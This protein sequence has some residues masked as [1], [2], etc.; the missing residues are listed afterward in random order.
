MYIKHGKRADEVSSRGTAT[1]SQSEPTQLNFECSDGSAARSRPLRVVGICIITVMAAE[2][3]RNGGGLKHFR[4]HLPGT[5]T[6]GVL[7]SRGREQALVV[8]KSDS[9]IEPPG[10]ED[11]LRYNYELKI[12]QC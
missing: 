10:V 12:Q 3:G 5:R 7:T 11:G 6:S 9:L 4:G 2:E 1:L 8:G